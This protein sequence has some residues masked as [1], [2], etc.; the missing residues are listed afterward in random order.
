MPRLYLSLSEMQ[1]LPI[2]IALAA[3]LGQLGTGVA[4]KLLARAS[5]RCDSF[6]KRRLQALA[7]TT[8]GTGGIAQGG[9]SLP[10]ASTLTFDNLAENAVQIGTGATQ[11]LV[12]VQAGG[13]TVSSYSAPYPGTLTLAAPCVYAHSAGEAVQGLY[14]EVSE[15]LHSSSNDT[16][17]EAITQEAE[18]A[19]AHM[20]LLTKGSDLTRYVFTKAYPIFSIQ[21]AEYTYS[22]DNAYYPLDLTALAIFAASGYYRLRAGVVVLPEGFI[23]TTYNGGFATVPD[24][25][26]LATAH[27]FAEELQAF[28]N[29]YGVVQQTMG[30][31]SMK[32]RDGNFRSPNVQQAEEILKK[33]RRTV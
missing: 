26:K 5:Q 4:D 17:T 2:G 10:V 31:R 13:V 15:A 14:Q 33:Y 22:Y 3:Q 16:Y 30:K 12:P 18:L 19:Q 11:E 29:P 7:A 20:P 21:K 24:D 6:C 9:T 32:F 8:V 27:Y 25:V 23:R 28:I 1:E